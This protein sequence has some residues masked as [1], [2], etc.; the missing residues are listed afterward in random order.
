MSQDVNAVWREDGSA[1]CY[2]RIMARDGTGQSV[3]GQGKALTQADLSA[4]TFKTFSDE[5]PNTP[6]NSGT[7]VIA[8]SIFDTLQTTTDDPVWKF[9]KGFNFRH[10]LGPENFPEG[11]TT[12]TVEYKFVTSGGTVGF[13]VFRGPA[14]GVFTS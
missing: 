9:S 12:Y 6:I 1:T 14:T 2:A 3:D 8:T 10:D 13:A 11:D 4:I 5:N 7:V